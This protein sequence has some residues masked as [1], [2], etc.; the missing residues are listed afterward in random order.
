MDILKKSKQALKKRLD[1]N[2]DNVVN[3]QD[4]IDAT[5]DIELQMKKLAEQLAEQMKQYDSKEEE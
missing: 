3:A 4:I 5:N 2:K 1:Y